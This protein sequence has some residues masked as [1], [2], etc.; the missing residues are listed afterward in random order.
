MLFP[1]GKP[2][3]T[4]FMAF[5]TKWPRHERKVNRIG[6]LKFWLKNGLDEIADEV[7]AGL[8]R[9][10]KSESWQKEGGRFIPMPMTW[11]NQQRWEADPPQSARFS[12]PR[13]AV[14]NTQ[15]GPIPMDDYLR[16]KRA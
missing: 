4:K 6:A 7:L 2:D 10:C 9:W 11:L 5:W 8:D 12:R 13:G 14:V 16:R 1:D 3:T 15:N